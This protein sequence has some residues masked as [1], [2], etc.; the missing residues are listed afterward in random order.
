ME[1][2]FETVSR[3]ARA[4][5]D[6]ANLGD[7]ASRDL[8]GRG[9]L[10][11][12]NPMTK[13][14]STGNPRRFWPTVALWLVPLLYLLAVLAFA[15]AMGWIGSYSPRRAGVL[16]GGALLGASAILLLARLASRA[17]N[18]RLAL[19]ATILL[20][21]AWL[22]E[23]MAGRVVRAK[24]PA[25]LAQVAARERG[26]PYDLRT[27]KQF[28]HE[29]RLAGTPALPILNRGDLLAPEYRLPFGTPPAIALAM[30]SRTP[31]VLG[32][33]NGYFA[34]ITTDEH[35]FNNPLGTHGLTKVDLLAL[36]DS[37]PMGLYVPQ[38]AGFMARLRQ[39]L[40]ATVNLGYSCNG[41]LANL[42]TWREYGARLRPSRVLWFHY[43]GNDLVDLDTEAASA[44]SNYL[45]PKFSH[46]LAGRQ[47][48]IDRHL[49]SV[50]EPQ[51]EHIDIPTW[52]VL[53]FLVFRGTRRA[54]ALARE[55]W[56]GA[57]AGPNLTL[58][59]KVL[60]QT[61]REVSEAGGELWLVY[62][63]D[64]GHFQ[65][66]SPYPRQKQQVRAICEQLQLRFIDLVP[67]FE[68]TGD[69]LAMYPFRVFQHYT[70][71][72]NRLISEWLAEELAAVPAPGV[73]PRSAS[74]Q[75]DS[76]KPAK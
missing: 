22:G 23:W 3:P 41:P 20:L 69:P 5:R 28:T 6:P 70:E 71:E 35:G 64:I 40:P 55:S 45:N 31:V 44:L 75:E 42:A 51:V 29:L 68:A 54:L 74:P 61:K 33:E 9:S 38:E 7:P 72:G 39:R 17:L 34:V 4:R 58:Y 46:G 60:E 2:G 26:V 32:N 30:V 24:D 18:L 37:F 10:L 57:G 19:L 1:W 52:P 47:P 53:D 76:T 62:L 25:F 36:G 8:T 12:M 50:L 49:R 13:P 66:Q 15:G 63:P 27:K 16:A 14:I 65:P 11:G 59:Q 56:A 67:E 73:S 48:E 43:E 21:G